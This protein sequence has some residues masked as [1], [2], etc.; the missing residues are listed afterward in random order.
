VKLAKIKNNFI[1]GIEGSLKREE[2][3]T[4][5]SFLR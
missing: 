5:G 1:M 4:I 2:S 3:T